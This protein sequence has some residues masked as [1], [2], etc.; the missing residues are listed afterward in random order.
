MDVSRLAIAVAIVAIAVIVAVVQRRRR[1]VDAPTQPA[2]RAPAQLDRHDFE[3][4]DTEWLLVVFTSA[5]C[6]TCAD[7]ARKAQVVASSAVH[8]VEVEYG[9]D[10]ELHRRYAIEAVPTTVLAGHDGVVRMSFLGP[11]SATDLWAAIAEAREPGSGPE[12]CHG[13]HGP[14]IG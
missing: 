6:Q 5:T 11:V 12:P 1:R 9:A 4:A 13:H 2:V 14:P 8:V 3:G 7:V 10:R